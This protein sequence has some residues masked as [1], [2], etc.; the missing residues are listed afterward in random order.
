MIKFFCSILLA[1]FC[2]LVNAQQL[3]TQDLKSSLDTHVSQ[4]S[5]DDK[6]S[7]KMEA[8]LERLEHNKNELVALKQENPELYITK[9]VNLYNSTRASLLMLLNPEQK[10]IYN[11]K[12]MDHRI[13]RNALK[14]ELSAQGKD[15]L[16]IRM[17][18]AEMDF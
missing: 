12:M 7:V 2:V 14:Q 9:R 16:S 11:E 6:Q 18:L 1:S 4:F 10:K 3:S 15:E 8:I 5:L 17:A 13:A